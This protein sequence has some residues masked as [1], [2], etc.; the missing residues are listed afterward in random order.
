MDI[1]DI[2]RL[3][4]LCGLLFPQVHCETA[5]SPPSSPAKMLGS[6]TLALV[7]TLCV[8]A[9][10]TRSRSRS[11]PLGSAVSGSGGGGKGAGSTLA[12]A[13]P[14]SGGLRAAS[15][16]VLR[17]RGGSRKNNR[18]HQAKK[19]KFHC[20]VDNTEIRDRA[21][22][23]KKRIDTLLMCVTWRRVLLPLCQRHALCRRCAY[24][25]ACPCICVSGCWYAHVSLCVRTCGTGTSLPKTSIRRSPS[26]GAPSPLR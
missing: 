5:G 3:C 22:K 25:S 15:T 10:H 21:I 20:Q 16:E 11:L 2:Q 17:L 6:P 14:M 12:F 8:V 1:L 24:W 7:A 19:H 26:A 4:A 13:R 9:S 23:K 18:K